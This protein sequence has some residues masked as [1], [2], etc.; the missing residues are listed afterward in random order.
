MEC[1]GINPEVSGVSRTVILIRLLDKYHIVRERFE[2]LEVT[3]ALRPF[4]P[5][6][7]LRAGKLRAGELRVTRMFKQRFGLM[8]LVGLGNS[9]RA[10]FHLLVVVR[11]LGVVGGWYRVVRL[12]R[13]GLGRGL[14][15][16]RR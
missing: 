5:S 15:P 8:R 9:F 11:G 4:D 7:A 6:T 1:N 12:L 13:R 10:G 16:V 3:A 14:C 2:I